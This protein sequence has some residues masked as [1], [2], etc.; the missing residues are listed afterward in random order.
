M[1][2]SR[3]KKKASDSSINVIEDDNDEKPSTSNEQKTEPK[4]RLF[5]HVTWNIDGANS[6][7][8]KIR[9]Q[10]ICNIII[11]EKATLIFLQEVTEEA[12]E[13]IKCN[14]SS[15]FEIFSGY[16][17]CSYYTLT[18]IAKMP[19]IKI[20]NNEILNFKQTMMGRNII[21][22]NVGKICLNVKFIKNFLF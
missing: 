9:I 12:E 19:N 16:T 11:K 4:Q 3:K 20:K 17:G 15:K 2:F 1:C 21:K 18:L 7:N 6:K 10:A 22:T 8:L 14:L 13:I 5:R